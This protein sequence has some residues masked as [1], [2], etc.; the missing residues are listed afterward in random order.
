MKEYL[1]TKR[2]IR[3][4]L[5][6]E[7][8]GEQQLQTDLSMIFKLITETQ[9]ATTREITEG[10]RPI[11]ECIE[12]IPQTIALPA[13]P[14]IQAPEGEEDTQ[15]F[16]AVAT[17]YLRKFATKSEADPMYGLYD[18]NGNF[19]IGNKPVAIIDNNVIVDDEEYEGTP[20]LW[21]LI[22]SKNPDENVDTYEDYDNYARLML[23]TNAIYRS[24]NPESNYSKSSKW[25][26]WKRVLKT[27]WDNRR[28]YDGSGVT[29]IL[30]DPNA[31]LERLELLLANQEAGHMGVGNE[32]VSICD[33]LKRQG[34]LDLKSHKKI[35]SIIKI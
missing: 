28:E 2:N 27:I 12:N 30:S 14:C 18:R 34:V 33:E 20:G 11:R 9:K 31:L 29:F 6:S 13:F 4:N 19:Y 7:R 21:E 26:K 35:I 1:E 16:G 23:K 17:K 15:Y 10:L 32:L 5:L 22:V 8:T 24:N 25:R 3:H